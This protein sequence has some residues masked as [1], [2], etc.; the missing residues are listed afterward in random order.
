[1][2][3]I[4][5]LLI[6]L[7][8]FTFYVKD[9]TAINEPTST[10][11]FKEN[12]G[13][14]SDQFYKS[15]P[16]ILFSGTSGDLVYHLK[17]NG[18]SYQLSRVDSWKKEEANPG[19]IRSKGNENIPD[20]VTVYRLDINW[21]NANTK[22]AIKKEK[23]IEG[24]DNY[25]LEV[26]PQGALNVKSYKQITYQSLYNGIDLKWYEK[27]GNLKYDYIVAAG[28][29]HKQIQLE[30][31]GAEKISINKKGELLIKTPL[32]KITEAAPYVTQN[33]K[34]LAS[35]WI[36]KNNI[37]S[38][39]IKNIDPS[40]AFI[41]DPLIRAWGT[42]YGGSNWDETWSVTTDLSGNV[43]TAGGSRSTNILS[44]ATLGSHQSTFGG[45][46]SG[47]FP[48]DALLVKFT[49]AGVRVWGTYYGGSGSD[50]N[51]NCCTDSFGNCYLLGL[52][53]STN[54][55][56][57]TT[58][59]AHQTVYGGGIQCGDAFLVKFDGSGARIWGTYYGGSGDDWGIGC[60]VDGA[61]NV[62]IA[63]GTPSQSGTV[64]ATPGC[65]QST[66]G[67]NYDAFLAKFDA[68][69]VRQWGTFY[70]GNNTDNGHGCTADA[71][72]NVYL[73]GAA[74]SNN[75]ITIATPGAHQTSYA[76]GGSYG[77]AFVAKFDPSGV[78]QWATYYGGNNDDWFYNCVIGPS[79]DLYLGG[80]SG[81]G[82]G[83]AIATPGTHQPNYGGG[84]SD[85]FLL[86]LNSSGVR[87]WSSYYGGSGNDGEGWS[88]V[89]GAGNPYLSGTTSSATGTVIATPC[90]YQ[91][92]YGG[93]VSDLFF[94]KLTSTG[95]RL[96]GSYYGGAL[97]E[98]YGV[99]YLDA[100][101][102]LYLSG[103]TASNTGT[104]IA[105]STSHQPSY[106]GGSY[107]GLLVKFNPCTPAL[108]P[109]NTA[110]PL[111][112]ICAGNSTILSSSLTCGIQW[113]NDSI[114]GILLGSGSNLNTP[115]LSTT[116]TFYIAD[117]SCGV[118]GP[119]TAVE[120]TV[121][122]LPVINIT[123]NDPLI[124]IG[125]SATLIANGATTYT[126]A[127]SS[128]LNTT[129]DFS[130]VAMPVVNSIY[131]VTGSNG[132]C[133][134]TNSIPINL[135]P[136]PV[137]LISAL[138]NK[139]CTGSVLTL[140]ASGAQTYSWL[141]PTLVSNPN[142]S[143]VAA[144]PQTATT[145][146][147][148]GVNTIGIV[149]C[150]ETTTFPVT[151]LPYTQPL[152]SGNVTICE[153]D[154]AVLTVNGGNTYNWAP[155][156]GLSN[157][158]QFGVVVSPTATSVYS[159]N[160]SNN[161]Y[162]GTTATVMVYVNPKPNVYAGRDTSFNLKEPM[163]ITAIGDGTLKWVDGDGISCADC[164]STQI[165]PIKNSCYVIEAINSF[166]CRAI[167]EVCIDVSRENV[168]YIPNTFTP[169][170]DGLN[171]EFYV[172]G[173]GFSDVTL[174]IFDRWGVQLFSSNEV[175]HGW[176]GKY[177]GQQCQIATYIY[178]LSYSTFGGKLTTR[179]GHVNLVR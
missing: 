102:N 113:Y 52:T 3:K 144:S 35:Q 103:T 119:R 42:Y 148:V 56:V 131:T 57:I 13:Q 166:G 24:Y 149:S 128:S 121:V 83:T 142:G 93:G 46:G 31:K 97:R 9:A 55:P 157:P 72:G 15:R 95:T 133:S 68:N 14:V 117:P 106:G 105:N 78:R 23:E 129:L 1:M 6:L 28:A 152:I 44:I 64:I 127:P 43:F 70:G 62:Y 58:P 17:N 94:T 125:Q 167:D 150:I 25:Y 80:T 74:K 12:K 88:G 73:L 99:C 177:Q 37:I 109:N 170:G 60:S 168:L 59:G 87:V 146:T 111:M 8:V 114:A 66:S 5:I 163:I 53:T 132:S 156:N 179:T 48:G 141:P 32:G 89:D 77:D 4:G 161:G 82:A 139:I 116:T 63:G 90:T 61:N 7:L 71:A 153:G 173:F 123:T 40:Q 41:I 76:G 174:E 51:N 160:V 134:G 36:I 29:D 143:V 140:T 175:T 107:D 112:T 147:L 67:G 135:V 126:W 75:T 108:P 16:D 136:K 49:S 39:D 145:F 11:S 27:S 171:D 34:Q 85:C 20:Q 101:G 2:K 26:C 120:V 164:P 30:F 130:V 19:L 118:P 47:A 69:G 45:L 165:F 124:C 104:V 10:I 54:S 21:L 92:I 96:W 81:S 65:H 79:G 169:N 50:Y 84:S 178:K 33:G 138:D 122:P 155:N 176:N 86:K 100:G 172:S 154:D 137:P 159:V 38:F 115:A 22:A 158:N 98:H 18:I 91:F 151:V 162:C 110:P